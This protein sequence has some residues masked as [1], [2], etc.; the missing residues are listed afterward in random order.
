MRNWL[1]S[2]FIDSAFSSDERNRIRSI[3][4]RAEKNPQYATSSGN[5]TKDKV[6]LLSI[7]EA[8]KYFT[9]NSE[10]M[11]TT[12][13]YSLMENEEKGFRLDSFWWL[14]SPGREV[15]EAAYVSTFGNVEI[16]GANVNW[17]FLVRP[18]IWINLEF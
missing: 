14:C 6:F 8:K 4:V 9:E 5:D 1:N 18:T 10:R 17:N 7:Q 15:N 2:T 3:V 11:C 16:S 12:T 13:H